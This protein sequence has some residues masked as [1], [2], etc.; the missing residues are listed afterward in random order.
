MSTKSV[1]DGIAPVEKNTKADFD[2]GELKQ[3]AND[4]GVSAIY[5]AKSHLSVCLLLFSY[6]VNI[7]DRRIVNECLQNE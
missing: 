2:D 4:H 3:L 7:D 6:A 5:E 1:E